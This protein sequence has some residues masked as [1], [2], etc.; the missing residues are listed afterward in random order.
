MEYEYTFQAWA[1]AFAIFAK[2]E[3]ESI[4]HVAAEHDIIY[5]GPEVEVSPE[6]KARLEELGWFYD[7]S[8]PCWCQYV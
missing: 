1:E 3:P 5:A 4:A 8:L 6:D 2:Y 7:K